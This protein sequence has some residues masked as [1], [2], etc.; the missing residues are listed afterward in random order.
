MNEEVNML[1]NSVRKLTDRI[2]SANS[3]GRNFLRGIFYGLGWAIGATV[4]AAAVAAILASVYDSVR[5]IP[6]FQ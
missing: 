2:E 6:F 5:N 1:I 3:P 4:I